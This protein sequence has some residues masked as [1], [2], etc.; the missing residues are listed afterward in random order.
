MHN[1]DLTK[2]GAR[3]QYVICHFRQTIMEFKVDQ[4][5]HDLSKNK[6]TAD[7][8]A[9]ILKTLIIIVVSPFVFLNWLYKKISAKHD[10]LQNPKWKPFVEYGNFKIEQLF[11][12]D[13]EIPT[14]LDY[15]SEPDEINIFKLKSNP[16][17][18]G[19]NDLYFNLETAETLSG[20]YLISLNKKGFGMTL[21]FLDK[22]N[23]DFLK[24]KDLDNLW[25][26][27]DE[28]NETTIRLR[29]ANSVNGFDLFVSEK[30]GI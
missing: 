21:W 28:D 23:G 22:K 25:W 26:S 20:L 2:N 8:V 17:I 13:T 19:L 12:A 9:F 6:F 7:I 27:L 24:V 18:K 1:L 3:P 5:T 30:N 11:I 10:N 15:P 14:D 16:E 29:G 4:Y